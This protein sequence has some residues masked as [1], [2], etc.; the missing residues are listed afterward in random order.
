V[1]KKAGKRKKADLHMLNFVSMKLSVGILGATGLTGIELVRLLLRHPGI[2]LAW[3]SSESQA[4]TA[5]A[6][7]YPAVE[8]RLPAPV[9]TLISMEDAQKLSEKNAPD[10]VFSCLPHAASAE[11][12]EPFLKNGKTKV[13]DLSADFRLGDASVYGKTYAHAH[14]NP[15]RLKEAVYGLTEIHRD[16]IAKARLVANPGCY[17]TSILLPLIPLLKD[18][19]IA[20]DGIIADSKSGVS[21]AGRKAT[22]GTHFYFVN[23]DFSAYKV[24]DTHRHL[25][26]IAEQLSLAIAA[27]TSGKPVSPLFTPH[28]VPME[29]GILSTIYADLAPGKTAADVEAAWH[30][31]YAGS[32][33][34][35][36]VR[37]LPHTAH[38][39]RTNE[40]RFMCYQPAGTNKLIV[41]SVLDNM[42]KGAS[43]QALQNFN[44]MFGLDE[45][46]GLI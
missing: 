8:G 17:P 39:A 34:V 22:E 32:P 46:T 37:T 40:C 33:F 42:V 20:R 41:V 6:S 29:R 5:Y 16:K 9:A 45:T 21:G 28:L 3:L 26:E 27:G 36:P 43:G 19:I 12:V 18:G 24:G 4:G 31:A 1:R 10:A 11:A 13:I 35:R 25:P 7:V 23:E 38:V 14:P 30:K 44:V 2:E 15:E